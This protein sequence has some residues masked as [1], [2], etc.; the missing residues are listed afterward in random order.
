MMEIKK[1]INPNYSDSPFIWLKLNLT[2][3]LS[4]IFIGSCLFFIKNQDYEILPVLL[5]FVLVFLL[6]GRIFFIFALKTP[7]IEFIEIDYSNQKVKISYR[8]PI[9][10]KRIESFAFKNFHFREWSYKGE[11]MITLMDSSRKLSIKKDFLGL[12]N[13]S[14][15]EVE[16]E[17]QQI[18]LPL[19]S[20]FG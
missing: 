16:K 12:E 2:I 19:K 11:Q 3:L 1:Y 7:L 8:Y 13:Q 17:F 6:L 20:I 4:F 18:A 5:L 15:F 9:F 14:Y 10:R